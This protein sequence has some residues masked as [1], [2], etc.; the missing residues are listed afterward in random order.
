MLLAIWYV[1]GKMQDVQEYNQLYSPDQPQYNSFLFPNL[2]I[3]LKMNNKN[4]IM[5]H[6]HIISKEEF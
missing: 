1:F 3:H 5:V 2:K 4:N 6:L